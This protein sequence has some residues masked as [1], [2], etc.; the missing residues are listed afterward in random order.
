M[1][2]GAEGIEGLSSYFAATNPP[3]VAERGAAGSVFRT[4]SPFIANKTTRY[5]Y[6]QMGVT[7]VGEPQQQGE[8]L[9]SLKRGE[10]SEWGT[11]VDGVTI[12]YERVMVPKTSDANYQE[13]VARVRVAVKE[14]RY[15]EGDEGR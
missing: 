5:L 2:F 4:Q 14:P 8:K 6:H 15:A 12:V 7:P 9:G 10:R 1:R 11:D 13:E 3:A